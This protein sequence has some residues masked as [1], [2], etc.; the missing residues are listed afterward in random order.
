MKGKTLIGRI[1]RLKARNGSVLFIVLVM[2]SVMII[3]ASAVYYTVS[4]N[5]GQVVMEY[6]EMQGY[7]TAVSM[8]DLFDSVLL[9]PSDTTLKNR[10]GNLGVGGLMTADINRS[11][12]E[13]I[14]GI[15]DRINLRVVKMPGDVAVVRTTVFYNGK[16]VSA[17]REYEIV[18][19]PVTIP[20][21]PPGVVEVPY[22]DEL[23]PDWVTR[24]VHH[25]ANGTGSFRLFTSVSG[26]S[27]VKVPT[28]F[29][30]VN[31]EKTSDIT[32]PDNGSNIEFYG[33]ISA[34]ENLKLSSPTLKILTAS[35]LG[36]NG[37]PKGVYVKG[38]FELS[39]QN[40]GI[41]N[42]GVIVVGGDF[43]LGGNL[44]RGIGAANGR[45]TIYV[46]GDFNVT[47]STINFWDQSNVDIFVAGDVN[48]P[49]DILAK[50]LSSGSTITRAAVPDD[51]ANAMDSYATQ[52]TYGEWNWTASSREITLDWNRRSAGTVQDDW[53]SAPA[54][55][56]ALNNGD[57][58][59]I[60]Y[61]NQDCTIKGVTDSGNQNNYNN[62]TFCVVVDT[63]DDPNKVVTVTLDD[64][65]G[66]F[67]WRGDKMQAAGINFSVLVKG[68]GTA[69]FNV[70]DGV[71]Y[72]MMDQ[73]GMMPYNLGVAPGD[74]V[75]DSRWVDWSDSRYRLGTSDMMQFLAA[76]TG[77]GDEAMQLRSDVQDGTWNNGATGVLTNF[78]DQGNNGE[79]TLTDLT[80]R[81][82]TRKGWE[83]ADDGIKMNILVG[84]NGG[85]MNF[86][87]QSFFAGF[88][89]APTSEY[90]F[91]NE[92]ANTGMMFGGM[93]QGSIDA[94]NFV[95]YFGI[96][97][98]DK[99]K[100]L[101]NSNY[102]G[103][104]GDG[105]EW[106]EEVREQVFYD[107]NTGT[108]YTYNPGT[109]DTYRTVYVVTLRLTGR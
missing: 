105:T 50:L 56:K 94:N 47:A 34:A 85:T 101:L 92:G 15:G 46:G 109:G 55:F 41:D 2:M 69:V 74:S 44:D 100:N 18:G 96:T 93:I 68:A 86:A 90:K 30:D 54:D 88:S 75:L 83:I 62:G 95:N 16:Q 17:T 19:T 84:S 79:M 10:I 7:E 81:D 32:G 63:G 1:N 65:S 48:I 24:T 6:S 22:E 5:T 52:S 13:T 8:L 87:Q 20:G 31:F 38:D 33:N 77:T 23:P 49:P 103:N 35:D 71:N 43:T 27:N 3:L 29:T 40:L 66:S 61:I 107:P 91:S 25:S 99:I 45:M 108:T 58:D 14:G 104:P 28:M 106:D 89:Y 57:K 11:T 70:A 59:N 73:D 64:P 37:N 97:P 9:S 60:R 39:G 12:Q 51:A 42:G 76:I 36:P 98:N 80:A 4:S 21:L 102:I 67:D 72:T 26:G 53:D 78:K 82:I